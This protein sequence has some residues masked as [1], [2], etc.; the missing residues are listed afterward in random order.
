[1]KQDRFLIGILA[2]I[3]ILAVISLALFFSRQGQAGYGPEDTP[4]GVISNYVLALQKGDNRKAYGYLSGQQNDPD[5]SHFQLFFK[6]NESELSQNS[7][8][9]GD[10]SIS[11]GQ[12]TVAVTVIRDTGSLFS[13]LYRNSDQAVLVRQ[14]GAWKISSLPYPFWSPEWRQPLGKPVP[15]AP[16]PLPAPSATPSG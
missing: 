14:G 10:A 15:P 8:E 11:G 12:A 4:Q 3:A 7:L 1:M 5:F 16:A 6:N 9:V 13:P 2:G